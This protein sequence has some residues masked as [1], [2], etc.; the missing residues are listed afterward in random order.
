[1]AKGMAERLSGFHPPFPVAAA[2]LPYHLAVGF[3]ESLPTESCV[4]GTA[5]KLMG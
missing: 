3:V 4:S 1:M 2:I 5:L